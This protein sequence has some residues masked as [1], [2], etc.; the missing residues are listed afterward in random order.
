MLASEALALAGEKY[1]HESKMI[2]ELIFN[3]AKQGK[4]FI[5]LDDWV[6]SDFV[7]DQLQQQ[8]YALTKCQNW[9]DIVSW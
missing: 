1:T 2:H 9:K 6:I 5:V 3:A 7:R 4:F 8:G